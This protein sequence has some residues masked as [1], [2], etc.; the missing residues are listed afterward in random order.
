[1]PDTTQPTPAEPESGD[2]SPEQ[3]EGTQPITD[4]LMNMFIRQLGHKAEYDKIY[5]AKGLNPV[6]PGEWGNLNSPQLQ[7]ELRSTAGYMVE[8]LYEAIGLLKNKPWKQTPKATDPDLFYGELADFWHFCLEFMILAG[9]MPDKVAKYYFGVAA[10]NDERR[11]TG[12]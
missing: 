12:Y 8:E 11:E 1:M 4:I 5:R 6:P 3:L 9:M 2:L 7:A 10:S